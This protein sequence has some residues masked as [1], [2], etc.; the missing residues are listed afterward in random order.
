[1]EVKE[2]D[3]VK[4]KNGMTGTIVDVCSKDVCMIELDSEFIIDD[5]WFMFIYNTDIASIIY[6]HTKQ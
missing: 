6:H 3:I 2:F 4:L 5:V 1:M